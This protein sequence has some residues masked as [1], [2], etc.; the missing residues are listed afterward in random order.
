[1]FGLAPAIHHRL[2]SAVRA[3]RGPFVNLGYRDGLVGAVNAAIFY[4]TAIAVLARMLHDLIAGRVTVADMVLAVMM[5]GRLQSVGQTLEWSLR[6]LS[7]VVR[8]TNRFVWLRTYAQKVADEHP[9]RRQPPARL[10][11]GLR[12]ENLSY[13]YAGADAASIDGVSL[14]LPAGSVVALVGEN[15]AG[16]STLVKLLA[17]MYQPSDGRILVDG[18][19]LRDF[20]VEAWRA[21]MSGAFQDY[22]RFELTAQ[23][24]IGLGDL[25]HLDDHDRVDLALRQGAAEGVLTSLPAGLET[26]LGTTWPDGVELSGG[27]WQRLA[28]ARGMMRDEPLLLV[29]DEPTAALDAATE[30]ALFER[31][32][33]A[34]RA[35]GGRGAVTVLVTHRFSTVAAADLVVVLDHG[36]VAEVGT[37]AALMNRGGH[38]AEL[39]DLQARGYR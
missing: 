11:R 34:A 8:T 2:G 1:V 30:H 15:G 36:R 37:H 28:I 17:G 3:W 32:A 7:R 38:Y 20:D 31:Y 14:D 23:R 29:L 12:L 6:M 18:T 13:R 10:E 39:Y 24:S 22:A 26:R 5:V 19:D 27:Q 4:G 21:R 9:G 33:E 16:K 25:P 35:A